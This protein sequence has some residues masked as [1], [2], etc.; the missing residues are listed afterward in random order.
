MNRS[1]NDLHTETKNNRELP[2]LNVCECPTW[3]SLFMC[4]VDLYHGP[5]IEDEQDLTFL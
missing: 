4:S 1:I 2:L 3:I 5:D